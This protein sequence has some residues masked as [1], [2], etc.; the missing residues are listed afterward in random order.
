MAATLLVPALPFTL[1]G[2][3]RE[4]SH[5]DSAEMRVPS[6]PQSANTKSAPAEKTVSL[7]FLSST[8]PEVLKKLAEGTDSTLLMDD[9][10]PGKFS[11]HDWKRH[12]ARGCPHSEP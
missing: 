11:R 3:D 10:P 4:Q 7:N 8:W 2:E 5:R 6:G 9:E 1:R 12:P